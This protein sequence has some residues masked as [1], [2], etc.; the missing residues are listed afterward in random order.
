MEIVVVKVER[1]EGSAV[2]TGVVRASVGTSRVHEFLVQEL[3]FG[4]PADLTP[5]RQYR[6]VAFVI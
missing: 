4:S 5:R 2:V 3:R 1:E 6:R